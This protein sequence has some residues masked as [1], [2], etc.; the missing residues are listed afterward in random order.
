MQDQ[1][2]AR[3]HIELRPWNIKINPFRDLLENASSG[4][5]A[6]E[7]DLDLTEASKAAGCLTTLARSFDAL[8]GL[9]GLAPLPPHPHMS[10]P[11][12]A[13]PPW[14]QRVRFLQQSCQDPELSRG[15]QHR[16]EP[17]PTWD[18]HDLFERYP[19]QSTA[20]DKT[21]L[22]WTHPSFARPFSAVG[23]RALMIFLS[24]RL[25]QGASTL[26]A[27]QLVHEFAHIDEGASLGW[28][29]FQTRP[30][31]HV[32]T[33]ALL[34]EKQFLEDI[35]AKTAPGSDWKKSL[36]RL[37]WNRSYSATE[38]RDPS[39]ALLY[40]RVMEAIDPLFS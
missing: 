1:S 36:L 40:L 34:A 26:A 27:A 28:E 22:V 13:E 11:L 16:G 4:P 6:P 25:L 38:W 32:E 15:E 14:M 21:V 8:V 2:R 30:P 5:G 39:E 37:E 12:P 24:P 35:L 20:M 17:W 29:A 23:P 7:G 19:W 31:E 33:P 9:R 18:W 3:P 10:G